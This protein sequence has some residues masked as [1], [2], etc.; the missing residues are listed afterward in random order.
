MIGDIQLFSCVGI[1]VLPRNVHI[2]AQM[3][4]SVHEV[5]RAHEKRSQTCPARE[6]RNQ[7]HGRWYPQSRSQTETYVQA[8]ADKENGKKG[9]GEVVVQVPGIEPGVFS[10]MGRSFTD[11]CRRH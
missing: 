9:T 6:I 8:G 7:A 1:S 4:Y 11:S 5:N 3:C 2:L 10:T